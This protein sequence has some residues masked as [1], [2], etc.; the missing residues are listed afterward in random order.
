MPSTLI[1]T[2]HMT[3]PSQSMYKRL[4]LLLSIL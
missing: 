1:E 4:L 2:V 3:N